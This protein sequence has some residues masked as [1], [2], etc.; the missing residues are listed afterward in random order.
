MGKI[1][2][3]KQITQTNKK[4]KSFY[5]VRKDVVNIVNTGINLSN[6]N[7]ESVKDNRINSNINSTILPKSVNEQILNPQNLS[8]S[9]CKV[10]S[11]EV[12]PA[13]KKVQIS[14]NRIFDVNVLRDVFL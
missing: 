4:R 2:R 11:I 7:S 13:N 14:G 12:T 9:S 6:V 3:I 10:Q 8:A 5:G 1:C